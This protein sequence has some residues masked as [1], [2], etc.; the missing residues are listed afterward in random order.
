[1]TAD[2]FSEVIE[3]ACKLVNIESLPIPPKLVTDRGIALLS[4][5][6]EVYL[7]ERGIGHILASPYHPQTN[8][9]IE[10]FH[11]SC[12]EKIFLN[13]QET[14]FEL[15]REIGDFI[16][17]YNTR[18]YHKAL[19][20]VTPDDVYYGKREQILENRSKLKMET[21]KKRMNINMS[22]KKESAG[23]KV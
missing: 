19:G 4:K 21:L 5:D 23:K 14:P 10:R 20:N 11:R 17:W 22:K 6:F 18:R 7:E 12:K 1:M 3:K 2:A 9:K 15:K 13:A 16:E 8:G